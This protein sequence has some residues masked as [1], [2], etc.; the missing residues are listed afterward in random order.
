MEIS[1]MYCNMV[2]I[3]P[4]SHAK[5]KPGFNVVYKNPGSPII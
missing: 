4:D 1:R 3:N 5:W 2:T